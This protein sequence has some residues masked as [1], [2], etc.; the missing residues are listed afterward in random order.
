[1]RDVEES[2][3]QFLKTSGLATGATALSPKEILARAAPQNQKSEQPRETAKQR[4]FIILA[5][6]PRVCRAR[7]QA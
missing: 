4:R 6:N 5:Q 7:P 3:R 2:R 1:M